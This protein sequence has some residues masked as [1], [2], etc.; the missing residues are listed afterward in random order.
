MATTPHQEILEIFMLIVDC[1][2]GLI[3]YEFPS[4]AV[5]ILREYYVHSGE[6]LFRQT[7]EVAR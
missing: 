4:S 3:P 2:Q 7:P 1:I 5:T 6:N